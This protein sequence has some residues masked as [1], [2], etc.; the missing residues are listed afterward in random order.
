MTLG[1]RR[2]LRI[3]TTDVAGR[4]VTRLYIGDDELP[5]TPELRRAV[6]QLAAGAPVVDVNR[7]YQAGVLE[8]LDDPVIP[9]GMRI[10][11]SSRVAINIDF[12]PVHV[13]L[14]HSDGP[15]L[16]S[17]KPEGS[18]PIDLF[19]PPFKLRPT[20][21]LA[22]KL[23]TAWYR[24]AAQAHGRGEVVDRAQAAAKL[25]ALA[26]EMIASRPDLQ[27]VW[28]LEG[29]RLVPIGPLQDETWH[30]PM[31]VFHMHG[32]RR[33]AMARRRSAASVALNPDVDEAKAEQELQQLGRVLGALMRG[34]DETQMAVVLEGTSNGVQQA[35]RDAIQHKLVQPVADALTLG[36]GLEP[37]QVRHLG[38]ASLLANLGGAFVL[39]D[40]WFIP[41][42]DSDLEQ[43]PAASNLPPLE[44]I[45]FTHHHWDHV[46]SETLLKMDKTVP[47]YVP[48]QEEGPAVPKVARMLVG[49]GFEKVMILPHGARIE[50]GDGGY[51]AAAPFHGEDPTLLGYGANTYVLGHGGKAAWVHVDSS[52]DRDGRSSVSEGVA[53]ALVE[54]HGPLSPV[55][56]TRRQERGTMIEYD[57]TFLLRPIEEWVQPTENC[58]TGAAFLADLA[59]AS[60]ASTVVLYSE[61]GAAWYP[62]L[63]DFLR[64][65]PATAMDRIYEDGWDSLDAITEAIAAKGAQTVLSDPRQVFTIGE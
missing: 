36:D 9:E 35:W 63:T 2:T 42:S 19:V 56:A 28:D 15:R 29:D 6:A 61:G 11:L 45:F 41:G 49:L 10:R 1:L 65:G 21:D 16:K 37:G 44:G 23:R 52:P 46:H 7:L 8:R 17:A 60:Q 62:E 22:R 33:D 59:E 3:E 64:R 48:E 5:A 54:A 27:P 50:V 26:A 14:P 24:L 57:W 31:G 39:V 12:R 18:L 51:V 34:A 20:L 30:Y 4:L 40:P 38:H 55:F 47:V 32:D 43:P 58:A 53:A 13:Q 25:R